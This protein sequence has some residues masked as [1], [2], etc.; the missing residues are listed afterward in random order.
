M[1]TRLIRSS[2]MVFSVDD[3]FVNSKH[4]YAMFVLTWIVVVVVFMVRKIVFMMESIRQL[5]SHPDAAD[6]YL[7][8][9]VIVIIL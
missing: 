9:H 2:E 6:V 8:G 4:L 3:Y 5:L 7:D 1:K